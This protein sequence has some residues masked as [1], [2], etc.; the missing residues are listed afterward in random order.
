MSI[1]PVGHDHPIVDAHGEAMF[2]GCHHAEIEFMRNAQAEVGA[3][4][5]VVEPHCGFPMRPFHEQRDTFAV[6]IFWNLNVTLIPGRADVVAL[7]LAEEWNLDVA[8]VGVGGVFR[9]QI[10]EMIVEREH[11]RSVNGNLVAV[12]LLFENAGQFD[13]VGEIFVEPFF[14]EAGIGAV[15]GETPF[16]GER[17][18]LN[19]EGLKNTAEDEEHEDSDFHVRWSSGIQAF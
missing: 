12:T 8:G 17:L 13:F 2:A 16:S 15:D 9:A 4:F 11:P 14:T 6:P 1:E 10:P 18:R 19:A 7:W 3:D 5:F